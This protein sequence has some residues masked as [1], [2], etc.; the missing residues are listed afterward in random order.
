MARARTS[1]AKFIVVPRDACE[2]LDDRHATLEDAIE[3][4]RI[5]CGEGDQAHYV[6]E[7]KAVATRAEP[8]VSV[9]K[10]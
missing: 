6:L 2:V 7:M 8:P 4:A 1:R 10:L 5:A 9:R 3:K